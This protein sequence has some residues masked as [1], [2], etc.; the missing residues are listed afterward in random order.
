MGCHHCCREPVY[1]AELEVEYMLA[2]VPAASL[3]GLK[4][5]VQQWWDGF[6]AHGLEKRPRTPQKG[7]CSHLLGYRS[8][9]LW[10]PMLVDGLC[11]AY[12]RRPINCRT[13]LAIGPAWQC[14]N[15][16]ARPHQIYAIASDPRAY[17]VAMGHM[18][19]GADRVHCR[20]DHLG[21]LLGRLLLGHQASSASAEEYEITIED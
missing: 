14:E 3:P 4:L 2:G 1:A 6:H 20:W 17:L 8:A 10:C 21:I 18:A 13:H 16:A 9:M 5:R 7:D 15:D 12:A 11:T 19:N